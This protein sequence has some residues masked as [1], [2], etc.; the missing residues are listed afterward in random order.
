M[1]STL[2]LTNLIDDAIEHS[3]P[4]ITQIKLN[5]SHSEGQVV[6]AV[7]NDGLNIA[8][9]DT[10]RLFDR[11]VQGAESK[12]AGLGLAIVNDAVFRQ[13]HSTVYTLT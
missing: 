7:E 13:K 5:T 12:G 6:I 9:M 3:A 8:H 10:D 2:T 1:T 4:T 11:F